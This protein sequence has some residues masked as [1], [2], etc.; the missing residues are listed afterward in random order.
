MLKLYLVLFLIGFSV[1]VALGQ[2]VIK[3]RV[4]ENK[5]RLSLAD[6]QVQNISNKQSTA[7][8]DKG[9]FSIPAKA[10]D[11]LV[12]GGFAYQ[13]DT[14]L[15]TD[16]HELEV[17][18]LPHQNFLDQVDIKNTST[19]TKNLNNYYD[20]E[21]HGQPL[22]YTRDDKMNYTGGVTLRIHWK[23]EEHK[24]EKQEKKLK[25]QATSDEIDRTFKPATIGKYVPLK[26]QEL[27]D[28][29]ALY[30]PDVKTY[31]DYSF[32]LTVYLNDCYQKYLK[33]P[34]DKRHVEKLK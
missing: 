20:P 23:T 22:V 5:T 10:G 6:I 25:D 29:I 32:N 34:V 33:L 13:P 8:N 16:M 14:V 19:D 12:F 18:L 17:F 30:T 11:M 28:F 2:S 24:R 27:N 31:S 4:Y 7:T 9:R 15:I 3:G 26:G 21:F 1:S